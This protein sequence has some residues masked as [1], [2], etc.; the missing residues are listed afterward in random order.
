MKEKCGEGYEIQRWS[1]LTGSKA[2]D[3]KYWVGIGKT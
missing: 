2:A 3:Q 1:S